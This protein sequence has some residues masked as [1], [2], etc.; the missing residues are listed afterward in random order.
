MVFTDS[1]SKEEGKTEEV[2]SCAT[3][4]RD[5]EEKESDGWSE[6]KLLDDLMQKLIHTVIIR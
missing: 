2:Q 1:L 5:E 4:P 6:I 3:P